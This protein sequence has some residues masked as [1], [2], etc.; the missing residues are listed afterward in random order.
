MARSFVATSV[1]ITATEALEH[2][3]IDYLAKDIA[4]LLETM[5]GKVVT[6]HSGT[7][8]TL[9]TQN[10]QVTL[11][12][13]SLR[14]KFLEI[15]SNPN[16]FYLLFMAGLV[17]IGYELSSPGMFFP[18]VL[19]GICLILALMATSVL[20]V[21]WAGFALILLGVGLLIA[22]AFVPSFGIL[23]IGGLVAFTLGSIFIIDPKKTGGVD[24]DPIVIGSTVATVG[25]LFLFFGF[26]IL[27]ADRAPVRSGV[28]GMV[29]ESGVV[30]NEF[31]DNKGQIR[32]A[33]AI[34]R[35]ENLSPEKPLKAGERVTVKRI[36]NLT[37]F[38]EQT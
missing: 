29:G 37:A 4:E 36:E 16:F 35:A 9:Q 10:A 22:E 15:I 34:W 18:G 7:K 31:I 5:D 14:Q 13:K 2:N 24:I 27:K 12:D 1:S 38:V 8:R 3:V 23:G 21:N 26:L 25:G 28:E 6:L 30:I 19:G 33:G 20:P 32:V 11:Y 17:G